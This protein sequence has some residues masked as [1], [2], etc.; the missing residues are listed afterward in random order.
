M[1]KIFLIPFMMFCALFVRAIKLNGE[2][3]NS[4][5]ADL[6]LLEK[7]DIDSHTP[8]LSHL[9]HSSHHS[10]FSSID[11]IRPKYIF[12]NNVSSPISANVF[13]EL[14]NHLRNESI[15][16]D[17]INNPLNLKKAY[18]SNIGYN[19]NNVSYGT[20]LV[21]VCKIKKNQYIWIYIILNKGDN[22]SYYAFSKYDDFNK[23][24]RVQNVERLDI[25]NWLKDIKSKLEDGQ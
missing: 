4:N 16:I 12:S 22:C 18:L 3:K 21:L 6:L 1:K 10:H 9:D 13:N 23:N 19:I 11:S 14:K 8:Y 24:K 7:S 15:T 5:N 17:G 25:P 20:A 2:A